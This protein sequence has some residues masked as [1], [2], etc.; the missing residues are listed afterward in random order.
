MH[1]NYA[2]LPG[3]FSVERGV[4]VNQVEVHNTAIEAAIAK[5]KERKEEADKGV[6]LYSRLSF[7]YT[8][9]Y[10]KAELLGELLEELER[11]KMPVEAV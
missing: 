6:E 8:N 11:L 1:H 3:G 5:V 10:Q 7:S 9:Y 2:V 4:V